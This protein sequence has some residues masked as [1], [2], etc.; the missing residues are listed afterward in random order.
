MKFVQRFSTWAVGSYNRSDLLAKDWHV[1]G[2]DSGSFSTTV[3]VFDDSDYVVSTSASLRAIRGVDN[4]GSWLHYVPSLDVS[5]GGTNTDSPLWSEAIARVRLGDAAGTDRSPGPMVL[6]WRT[7]SGSPST[8]LVAGAYGVGLFAEDGANDFYRFRRIYNGFD[9]NLAN[10]GVNP[11]L[12]ADCYM[13][14]QLDRRLSSDVRYR[15][16]IWPS[17][18]VEPSSWLVDNALSLPGAL[19]TGDALGGGIYI[20][21]ASS[22]NK[23]SI[24]ALG[25]SNST[26]DPVTPNQLMRGDASGS[27]S[28]SG[29][30]FQ[31]RAAVKWST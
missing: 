6:G 19:S 28:G 21:A 27:T 12:Y 10:S 8:S 14:F 29:P 26:A 5:R 4:V 16:R 1:A 31:F 9:S 18:G 17:T 13:R 23:G 2:F 15:A 22:T 11:P 24:A 25:Y 7:S 3:E 30:A 20:F